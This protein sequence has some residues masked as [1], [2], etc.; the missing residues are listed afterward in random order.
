MGWFDYVSDFYSSISVQ[1]ASADASDDQHSAS[2]DFNSSKGQK[3]GVGT[4]QHDRGASVKGG[5]STNT[6][7]SGTDE[8]SDEEA[9][10]NKADAKKS[11][12]PSAGHKQGGE[13]GAEA[14]GQVGRDKAGPHGGPVG[15]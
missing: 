12:G 1:S 14:A 4:A 3:G 8:E 11:E 15:A 7:H 2:G 13:G 10:V 6:P 9:E 5:V